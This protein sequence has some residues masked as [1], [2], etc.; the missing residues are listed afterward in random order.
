MIFTLV[1][2]TIRLE[3]AHFPVNHHCWRSITL[4]YY[5]ILLNHSDSRTFESFAPPVSTS[6]P[7]IV[8][9]SEILPAFGI[10][11]LLFCQISESSTPTHPEKSDSWTAGSNVKPETYP[12][13]FMEKK[14]D[15]FPVHGFEVPHKPANQLNRKTVALEQSTA[16]TDSIS[17]PLVESTQQIPN[18]K[19]KNSSSW[20]ISKSF[21]PFT[22]EI[23]SPQKESFDKKDYL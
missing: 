1:K 16:Q 7:A 6:L 20:K 11:K 19:K 15:W 8:Y 9:A 22:S 18:L 17:D 5:L 4:S 2:E 13:A 21:L 23:P 10:Y 14:T 12:K 3:D